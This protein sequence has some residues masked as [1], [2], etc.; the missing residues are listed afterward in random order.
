[1]KPAMRFLNG[2]A[3]ALP[4]SMVVSYCQD[5]PLPVTTSLT[6]GDQIAKL[7]PSV[8]LQ[9]FWQV[10]AELRMLGARDT[11]PVACSKRCF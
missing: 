11:N 3:P 2:G 8:E 9:S 1:M 4:S 10:R 5:P 7:F 6:I